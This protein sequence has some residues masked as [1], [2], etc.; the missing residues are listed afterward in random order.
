MPNDL[1]KMV[2]GSVA[3]NPV[4]RRVHTRYAFTAAVEA[5]DCRQ[6]SVLNARTGDIGRG[7]CYIDAFSPFPL[8]TRV[9]LRITSERQAFEAYANVVYSKIGMGMGMEFSGVEPDHLLV[10]DKWIADLSGTAPVELPALPQNG[11]TPAKDPLSDEQWITLVE[12]TISM[13]RR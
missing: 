1:T 7:G 11:E 3:V 8:K 5:V 10:L 9:K 4:E 6:R 12:F 2:G 13:V